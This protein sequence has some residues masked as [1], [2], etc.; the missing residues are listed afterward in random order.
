MAVMTAIQKKTPSSVVGK[1]AICT[2]SPRYGTYDP[3]SDLFNRREVV[4]REVEGCAN[5]NQEPKGTSHNALKE[6]N[7]GRLP[8]RSGS[9]CLDHGVHSSSP[10]PLGG[11]LSDRAV[12]AGW[13]TP[14]PVG[15]R[16]NLTTPN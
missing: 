14:V 12:N 16:F 11:Q 9:E 6:R 4:P 2:H 8:V 15:S 3:G 7:E 1:T 5:Q 13:T 10:G